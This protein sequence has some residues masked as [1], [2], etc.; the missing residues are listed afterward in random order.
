MK[1]KKV[2]INDLSE[3]ELE[4]LKQYENREISCEEDVIDHDLE[5]IGA[6]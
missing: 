1:K 4:M 5:R 6:Y 3:R 2:I